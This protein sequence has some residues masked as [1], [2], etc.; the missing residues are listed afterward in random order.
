METMRVGTSTGGTTQWISR[1]NPAAQPLSFRLEALHSATPYAS[2][3]RLALA[4]E[5]DFARFKGASSSSVKLAI[6][7]TTDDTKEGARNLTLKARNIGTAT[8]GAWASAS[9]SF[10]DP[11]RNLKGREAFGLWIKG[12]GKGALLNLQ[13]GTPREHL[14]ALSDHHVKLDFKGWRYVEILLRERDTSQ[15]HNHIWPYYG[16]HGGSHALYRNPVQMQY[17][18]RLSIYLNDLP[19]GQD[20]EVAISPIMAVTTKSVELEKPELDVNGVKFTIPFTL[21]SGEYAELE[22]DGL[23]SHYNNKGELVD[24]RIFAA[25]EVP[26]LVAGENTITYAC[27][28]AGAGATRAEV[29]V[30]HFSEPFGSVN[31]ASAGSKYLREE[32]EMPRRV[33]SPGGQQ[34]TWSLSVRPDQKP[35]KLE[36]EI[37]GEVENPTLEIGGQ[38]IAFP[39]KLLAEQRLV[40][41]DGANWTVI[42]KNRLVV[43]RGILETPPA[44]LPA[45]SHQVR[46]TSTACNRPLVKLTKLYTQ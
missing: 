45:G 6:G 32:Y 33:I 11:Y 12:D 28:F 13:L 2:A 30:N 34:E 44:V 7:E 18:S 16:N 42:G 20:I 9:L 21:R 26:S 37:S 1:N 25:S 27:R 36:I 41:R 19:A 46:F 10:P 35:A 8:K 24:R 31:P 38:R 39:V 5:D 17:V 43:S 4:G 23:C 14:S 40:C 3:D 22:P 29:S 15:L